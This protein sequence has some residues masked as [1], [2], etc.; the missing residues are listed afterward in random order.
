MKKSTTKQRLRLD[1][2][3]VKKQSK[4]IERGVKAKAKKIT[5]TDKKI[6]TTKKTKTELLG[7]KKQLESAG[8]TVSLKGT[9][10]TK[11][12]TND[13]E[14]GK[15]AVKKAGGSNWRVF[16]GKVMKSGGTM[17]EAATA[18]REKNGGTSE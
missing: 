4:K 9:K 12:T 15:R 6:A 3:A 5:A 18:W 13:K 1:N 14:P 2:T 10:L 11:K 7:I 17:K 8:Y 16:A